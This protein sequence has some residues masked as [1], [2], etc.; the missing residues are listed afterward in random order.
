MALFYIPPKKFQILSYYPKF[1][2]IGSFSYF[3]N[4]SI[5]FYHVDLTTFYIIIPYSIRKLSV[6]RIVGAATL[7]SGLLYANNHNLESTVAVSIPK[8]LRRESVYLPSKI[9]EELLHYPLSFSS[10]M[11]PL[12]SF[13]ASSVPSSDEKEAYGVSKDNPKPCCGCL[14][15]D[16]IANAAAS[17]APAVVNI[18]LHLDMYGFPTGRAIGSGTIIDEDGTILTCAHAVVDFHGPRPTTKG[19]VHVTLQDGRTFEGRVLNADFHSDIAIIKITSKTPLPVAKLGSSKRLQPGDWVLAM[20]CPLSLHNTV[21]AGI[22]S[23]VDRK[24]SDLGLGG[25]KREY[26]QADCAIN[27]GNS[28]GPLVNI[29]GEVIGINIMKLLDADGVGFAVPIDSAIKILEQFKKRGRVVRPWLGLKMLELNKMV[30]AQLKERNVAFPNVNKG[31]L[32][33][34]VTPGSPA[35]RDGFLPGD[36]VIEFDGQPVE[37]LEE[38]I[39]RMGDKVGE[40]FKVVVRRAKDKLVTLTVVPEESRPDI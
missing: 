37:R 5:I 34:M 4:Y 8:P 6:F 28:G 12:F 1:S 18:S 39:E 24:S 7:G 16:T 26:I 15:R 19:K 3:N 29:D 30:I 27:P 23:C 38:I 2:K 11:L 13:R 14:G 17:V 22:V 10:G 20:G 35:E 33:L 36:V 25:I 40:P 9:G 32:V 21:T 31:V